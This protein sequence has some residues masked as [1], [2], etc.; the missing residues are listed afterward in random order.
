MRRF[1]LSLGLGLVTTAASGAD[2]DL[3]GKT[4][5]VWLT[6]M[7]ANVYSVFR[8]AIETMP[9]PAASLPA[10]SGSPRLRNP[11]TQTNSLES[12]RARHLRSLESLRETSWPKL[13]GLSRVRY[14]RTRLSSNQTNDWNH[15]W[16]ADRIP[17]GI[18]ALDDRFA[19]HYLQTN[20]FHRTELVNF[21]AELKETFR[22]LAS[23]NAADHQNWRRADLKYWHQ[24]SSQYFETLFHHA[25]AAAWFGHTNEAVTLLHTGFGR[26]VGVSG[27]DRMVEGAAGRL[28]DD[29]F[30]LFDA[31]VARSELVE[32]WERFLRIF[33]QSTLAPQLK[34]YVETMKQQLAEFS[35]IAQSTV[36]NP[37]K[38][39]PA[40]RSEYY[41]AR[42]PEIRREHAETGFYSA[43]KFDDERLVKLGHD[44]IPAL[45][46]HLDDRRFTRMTRGSYGRPRFIVRVQDLAFR[47]LREITKQGYEGNSFT[48]LSEAS[49]EKRTQVIADFRDWWSRYG[50]LSPLEAQLAALE[51][52][53]V[54]ERLQGLSRLMFQDRTSVDEL[55]VLRRWATN[56]PPDQRHLLAEPLARRGDSSLMPLLRERLGRSFGVDPEPLVRFGGP[57]EVAAARAYEWKRLADQEAP[58]LLNVFSSAI[59]RVVNPEGTNQPPIPILIPLIADALEIRPVTLMS[60]ATGWGVSS[61]ADRAMQVL[62][63]HVRFDSG[64]RTNAPLPER[65]AAM[66]R[67]MSWWHRSGRAD[68]VAAHPEAAVVCMDAPINDASLRAATM[69]EFVKVRAADRSAPVV[70]DVPRS[71]LVDLVRN[72]AVTGFAIEGTRHFWFDSAEHESHWLAQAPKLLRP[73]STQAQRPPAMRATISGGL[74]PDGIDRIWTCWGT[75]LSWPAI[76]E[77]NTWRRVAATDIPIKETRTGFDGFSGAVP[78]KKS[79]LF[80][81]AENTLIL[82]DEKGWMRG[83]RKY[84]FAREDEQRLRQSLSI[85]PPFSDTRDQAVARDAAGNVWFLS[86]DGVTHTFTVLSQGRQQRVAWPEDKPG[87]RMMSD[88]AAILAPLGKGESVL[89]ATHSGSGAVFAMSNGVPRK[90]M[91]VPVPSSLLRRNAVRDRRGWVWLISK[92]KSVA[93]EA[94]GKVVASLPGNVLATDDDD[95]WLSETRSY[96]ESHLKRWRPGKPELSLSLPGGCHA[97]APA[98]DGTMWVLTDFR[99]LLRVGVRKTPGGPSAEI[100]ILERWIG[101]GGENDSLWCDE[102]GRVWFTT[103]SDHRRRGQLTCYPMQKKAI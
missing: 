25:Y 83:G 67:W 5:D 22:Y 74:W 77:N 18:V 26:D 28:Y 21:T 31:G 95:V 75:Y 65:F 66:D 56:A 50:K 84:S 10:A 94:S 63:T 29:S 24:Q 44:A 15:A 92:E 73:S 87:S 78:G 60:V 3:A 100:T 46:N 47:C 45:L 2:W 35:K 86:I 51:N 27:L 59:F 96:K 49:P 32:A 70:Y 54:A 41:L 37:D 99:Q 61:D 48:W 89:V 80:F 43:P 85:E 102:V 38:L 11:P 34:E 68:H 12:L 57:E 14:A 98:P 103:T 19:L 13:T 40:E 20:F 64:Y 1:L 30:K 101:Q 42:F 97:A 17:S 93:V 58:W 23:T 6:E 81:D 90:I 39:P 55:A 79:I 76:F 69:P 7:P 62:S 4:N 53:P 82:A 33:P 72:K 88:N 71:N 36:E 8:G 9:D 91:D 52:K 16:L